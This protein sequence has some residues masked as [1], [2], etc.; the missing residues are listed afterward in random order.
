[1]LIR[2]VKDVIAGRAVPAVAPWAS[3]REAAEILDQFDIGALVVLDG[4]R[5]VGLLSERDVLRKV[6][7]QG[8]APDGAKV[9][10]TMTPDPV[11]VHEDDPLAEAIARME[12]GHFRHLPVVDGTGTCTGL[13]SVRDIPAEY[14]VMYER[15][16]ELRGPSA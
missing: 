13:L 12:A 11:T 4:S 5:L 14:R 8:R 6:V 16:R 7:G 3:I 15:F 10:E 2:S 9:A 1:M